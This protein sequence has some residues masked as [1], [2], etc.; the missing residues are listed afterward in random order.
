MTTT[1]SS[2]LSRKRL[3]EEKDEEEEEKG[4]PI[5]RQKTSKNRFIELINNKHMFFV[6]QSFIGN[7][8]ISAARMRS[9]LPIKELNP[10]FDLSLVVRPKT[11]QIAIKYIEETITDKERVQ[12]FVRSV[13]PDY[14]HDARD[15]GGRVERLPHLIPALPGA[16]TARIHPPYLQRF[17]YMRPDALPLNKNEYSETFK[18]IED[19]PSFYVKNAYTFA[20]TYT[21]S[22]NP[23][24]GVKDRC[25][26]AKFDRLMPWMP[27]VRVIFLD[28]PQTGCAW[29]DNKKQLQTHTKKLLHPRTKYQIQFAKPGEA[30]IRV[31]DNEYSVYYSS[32]EYNQRW[33]YMLNGNR[34]RARIYKWL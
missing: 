21:P 6:I 4:Q 11:H 10:Y 14:N 23:M 24:F 26:V 8:C 34:N 7:D 2:S 15:N 33:G 32:L 12:V 5:K 3:L 20:L 18:R 17:M 27:L 29:S 30:A 19:V 25:D 16:I 13:P 1:S 28:N 9:A 31:L 22:A